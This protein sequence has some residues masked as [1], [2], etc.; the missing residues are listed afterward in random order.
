MEQQID[1]ARFARKQALEELAGLGANTRQA[2]EFGKQ[3]IEKGGPHG[4]LLHPW[5]NLGEYPPDKLTEAL[6]MRGL[7]RGV[8]HHPA[9]FLL[10]R[11]GVP[12]S[13]PQI[14]SADLDPR[15]RRILFRAHHRGMREMDILFGQF[16]DAKLPQMSDADL[17]AFEHLL[18]Q[19]TDRD[20]F[21]WL[22]DEAPVEPEF[23][24]AVFRALKAFHTHH[25]ALKL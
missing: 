10:I 15:R 22:T 11:P 21:K 5:L 8:N 7:R 17:E 16:A 19:V 13:S 20:A 4:G 9:L 23:D 3:R 24:T 14:S 25:S 12:M 6:Y 18:E 2:G 1:N